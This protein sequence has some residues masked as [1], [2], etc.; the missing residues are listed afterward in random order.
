MIRIALWS[1]PRNL[2]TAMMRAFENRPDTVVWD[3]PLYAH[4]LRTTGID[5]PMR[6]ET[7][8][9]HEADADRV[10]DACAT[11][12]P[13]GAS[14]DGTAEIF[15]Q[16]QMTH[17]FTADLS[18]ER[19][20][21]LRHAFLIRD[22]REMLLSY[23]R[24]RSEVTAADLGLAREHEIF[25][26]LRKRTGRVPPVVDAAD[27][28]RD[29]RAT[30]TALCAAL[31]VPFREEMLA[32]PAGLRDSDGA[33]APHWY[34]S[35]RKSTGFAPWRPREGALPPELA[36]VLAEARIPYEALAEHRIVP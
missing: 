6:E 24:K 4:Y 8:A 9:A 17:H 31:D 12:R 10:L 7:L 27:V 16:K 22:P 20:A 2:S 36:P 13:P 25:E 35:V 18:I 14:A 11:G 3:E 34:D 5:H 33:W 19:L 1:G 30:L 15:Y 29:P 21:G 23:V 26:V 28:L 32:W